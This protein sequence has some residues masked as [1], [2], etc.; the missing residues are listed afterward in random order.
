MVYVIP[1]NPGTHPIAVAPDRR[2]VDTFIVWLRDAGLRVRRRI[3]KG[4]D[5]M[6]ACG[7]LG[8]LELRRSLD[9]PRSHA[10]S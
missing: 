7:Q 5:V 3:T 6:A 1:Y 10:S 9:R 8:N 2:Q 4:R